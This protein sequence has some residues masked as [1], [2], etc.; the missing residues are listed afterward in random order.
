MET[1]EIHEVFL[2]SSDPDF[3]ELMNESG[4]PLL[5][6]WE[7]GS[8]D[9]AGHYEHPVKKEAPPPLCPCISPMTLGPGPHSQASAST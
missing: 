5:R 2:M 7:W 3:A 6:V 8:L 4:F 9:L 1:S